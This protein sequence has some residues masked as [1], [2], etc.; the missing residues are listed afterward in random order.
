[1]R[2]SI[3]YG[4]LGAAAGAAYSVVTAPHRIA[5][6]LTAPASYPLL[7]LACFQYSF[8]TTPGIEELPQPIRAFA[9]AICGPVIGTAM[10]PFAPLVILSEPFQVPMGAIGGA[11][12]GAYLGYEADNGT[13]VRETVINAIEALD[14][15][16]T[17]PTSPPV[18]SRARQMAYAEALRQAAESIGKTINKEPATAGVTVQ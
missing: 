6:A 16:M 4:L 15:L 3:K 12:I 1:M 8:S 7:G 2:K 18:G 11:A 17:P 14:E 9:P 10:V 5:M 13:P